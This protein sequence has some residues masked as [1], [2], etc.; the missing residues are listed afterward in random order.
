MFL[1][2][3]S[4]VSATDYAMLTNL[5]RTSIERPTSNGHMQVLRRWPLMAVSTGCNFH[6]TR[7]VMG[8]NSALFWVLSVSC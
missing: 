7:S 5:S 4:D 8:Y 2:G 3:E 1:F 6:L